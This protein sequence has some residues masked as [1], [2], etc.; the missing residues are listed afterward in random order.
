[1]DTEPATSK[2]LLTNPLTYADL[3]GVQKALE[4]KAFRFL[5]LKFRQLG[6]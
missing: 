5:I 3:Q 6:M 2:K 1:M 4:E